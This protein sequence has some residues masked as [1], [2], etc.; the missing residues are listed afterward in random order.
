MVL[1]LLDTENIGNM[2]RFSRMFKKFNI[3]EDILYVYYC[4]LSWKIEKLD[5]MVDACNYTVGCCR[6]VALLCMRR[7]I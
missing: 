7:I 1:W 5:K 6:S 2:Y 4:N 3:R